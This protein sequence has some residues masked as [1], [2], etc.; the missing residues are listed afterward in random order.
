MLVGLDGFEL[1]IAERLMDEGRL[2]VLKRLR[3]GG[4]HM[5][6]DHGP[7]KRTGLAW[8]HVATGLSPDAAKRWSAVDFDPSRYAVTQ[9]PT[10]LLPFAAALPRRTVVFDPPY[11]D[12]RRTPG[13][14]GLVNWGAHDPGVA[15]FARPDGLLAEMEARFGPYPAGE[16]IYGFVWP[17]VERTERLGRDLAAALDRRSEITMW[18]FGERLPDWDFGFT[19]VSEYHSAVEAL[20]HGSDP[21]HPL[22]ALPSAGPARRGLEAVYEAGDRMLGRLVDRFPEATFVVFNL[23]GMGTNNADVADL[24]LLPELLYR[25]AFGRALMRDP[26]WPVTGSGV[27]VITSD[28]GWEDE[29]DRVLPRAIRRPGR[30]RRGLSL[31]RRSLGLGSGHPA[32]SLDWM[33]GARYRRFW[34]AMRAFAFPSFYDGQIRINLK[35]RE[36]DGMVDPGDYDSVCDEVEALIAECRDPLT[37]RPVAASIRRLPDPLERGPSDTDILIL[38]QGT[39]IGFDHPRLGRIGPL[40][41]RRPGGHTGERGYASIS[42]PGIA[43]RDLGTR[44]AFD[45]VPTVI[46]LLG[47]EPLPTSGSSFA[48]DLRAEPV[49]A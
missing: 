8:E 46:D 34:P 27:P 3:D 41:F 37:G 44:S 9:K 40:P 39:P 20:W 24:A 33:P 23:H 14:R 2:P 17:S 36:A 47:A 18:L 28:S 31:L 6:L 30:M 5:V 32:L 15:T 29:I 45:V 12:L 1:S 16:W 11:F 13:V 26:V 7:A 35:G 25:H 19:V 48:A 10:S 42:G 21:A 49:P 22:H 38:W 4:A 43:R